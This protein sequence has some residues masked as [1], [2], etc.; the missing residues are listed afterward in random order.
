MKHLTIVFSLFF[1]LIV[2][3]FTMAQH[4]SPDTS[5]GKKEE[6]SVRVGF[7][8][9][10]VVG[11]N[12]LGHLTLTGSKILYARYSGRKGTVVELDLSATYTPLFLN[13]ND[14]LNTA[15]QLLNPIGGQANGSI[16]LS[17]PL[18]VSENK[19]SKVSVRS[20]L[21]W[22]EA[23]PIRGISGKN[24]L[25]Q[26]LEGGWYFQNLL[27]ED[28]LKNQQ[29]YFLAFPHGFVHHSSA[30]QRSSFFGNQLP[31]TAVGYGL[32]V[33]LELNRQLQITLLASQFLNAE[34]AALK[35][36][37]LALQVSYV[38]LK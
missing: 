26:Y 11:V 2:C 6:S 4:L 36:V 20:G 22:V 30:A 24:F 31:P 37:V 34:S 32:E 33:G 28:P 16:T 7:L 1:C 13:K 14:Q 9:S 3:Q 38:L 27:A 17:H 10:G 25:D 8:K 21:K 35:K 12:T 15:S 18:Q 23:I 5:P 29:L 19:A